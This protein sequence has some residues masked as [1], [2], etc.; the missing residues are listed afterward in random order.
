MPIFQG[1]EG[2]GWTVEHVHVWIEGVF[3]NQWYAVHCCLI[4]YDAIP[5]SR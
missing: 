5:F 3:M 4:W 2:T 1:E